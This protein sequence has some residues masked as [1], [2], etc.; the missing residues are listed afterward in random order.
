MKKFQ[1]I[2]L[3]L[4][5]ISAFALPQAA[6]AQ[7]YRYS[8]SAY[9]VEAYIEEDGTLSLY[10]YMEFQNAPNGAAIDFVDIG[11]PTSAFNQENVEAQV[12]SLPITKV[13]S[14]PYVTYGFA[15][16]LEEKAIPP[17]ETGVVTVWIPGIG[18]VLYEYTDDDHE[19]Y[20][21]FLFSPNW[22]D[23]SGD[24]TDGAEY[25]MTIVLPPGAGDVRE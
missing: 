9:E 22:L 13:E 11:L 14:S 23:P 17:G 2:L 15:L 6:S 25:R 3:T 24:K 20:A 4:V 18:N 5:L 12:D 19:N 21:S 16:N 10:Y 8:I 1:V 7:D